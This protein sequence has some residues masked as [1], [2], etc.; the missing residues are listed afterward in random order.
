MVRR[1]RVSKLPRIGT[2]VRVPWGIGTAEGEV[3][4]AYDSGP[5]PRVLVE[6]DLSYPG[7]TLTVVFPLHQVEVADA[8]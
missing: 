2:R 7:S 6:V 1:D 5:G 3:V 4:D 8:A